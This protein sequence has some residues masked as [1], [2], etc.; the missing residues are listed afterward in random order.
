MNAWELAKAHMLSGMNCSESVFCAV[1]AA[2]GVA[3]EGRNMRLATALAGGVGRSKEE[4]CGALSG[5]ILALGSLLGRDKPG[6]DYSY[7]A[8]LADEFR[9][10]FHGL[11]GATRCKDILEALG[12]Q[13]HWDKCIRHTADAAALLCALLDE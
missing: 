5:G 1:L 3:E 9:L 6:E 2:R 11:A 7:V 4:M 12:P 10:R 8:D 13:G